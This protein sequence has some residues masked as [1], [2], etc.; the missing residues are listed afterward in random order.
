MSSSMSIKGIF[1]QAWQIFGSNRS[2]ILALVLI[3][4][5]PLE[6]IQSYADY[7]VFAEDDFAKSFRLARLLDNTFG[8]I[9]TGGVIFIGREV[10]VGRKTTLNMAFSMGCG[11]WG[12]MVWTRYIYGMTIILGL[13]LL[14]IPGLYLCVRLAFI[15]QVVYEEKING[16]KAMR[17]CFEL[18]KGHFWFLLRFQLAIIGLVAIPILI[19][20]VPTLFIPA[21]DHW[22]YD[23]GVT[24]VLDV[25]IAFGTIALLLVYSQCN[26]LRQQLPEQ[27]EQAS[28]SLKQ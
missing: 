17:R 16:S 6:L 2:S 7:F 4:W 9:A 10:L 20:I 18:T 23:A 22:L 1:Q 12:R 26:A 8:I 15:D 3:V 25:V 27:I 19:L 28:P 24:L 11:A 13:L 21:M 5:I 14:V